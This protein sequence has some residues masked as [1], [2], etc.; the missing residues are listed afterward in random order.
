MLVYNL[1]V[2]AA[3]AGAVIVAMDCPHELHDF[4]QLTFI[5]NGFVLHSP[6]PAHATHDGFESVHD[7]D[8]DED[9][10]DDAAAAGVPVDVISFLF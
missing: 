10:E 3:A 1:P 5:Q 2:A 6:L 4:W 9:D 7:E 8:D